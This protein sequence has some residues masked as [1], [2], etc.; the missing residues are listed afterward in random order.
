MM[1]IRRAA[2]PADWLDAA[3]LLHDHIEWIRVAAGVDVVAEQPALAA[4]LDQLEGQYSGDNGS[5]F[6]A[7]W[8]EVAV[9]IVAVRFH[10][11]H[12]AELKRMYVRPIA[13]GRGIG[14]ALVVAV[15]D[16]ATARGCLRVWLETLPGAMDAAISVYR[17]NGFRE[18]AWD[19][20]T[21]QVPGL[22]VMERPVER[23][24]RSA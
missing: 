15:V 23:H 13:R 8:R 5:L 7:R 20:R 14:G 12:T 11:D 16:A 6:L 2:T 10:D 3:A 9:G 19:G 24:R 17:R 21:L 4:E 1:S 22:V 18:T